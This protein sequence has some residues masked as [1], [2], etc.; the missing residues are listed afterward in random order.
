MP[1]QISVTPGAA[2]F[3]D[4]F[5]PLCATPVTSGGVPPAK[6][7]MNGVLYELSNVDLW[8]SAGA[9]FQWSETLHDC[10]RRIPQRGSRSERGGERI[11]AFGR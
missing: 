9:G 7:D 8:M 5:P 2:S 1:S 11:L 3:T 6:A 10:D 4:G